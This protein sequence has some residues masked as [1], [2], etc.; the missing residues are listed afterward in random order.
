M[1]GADTA[2]HYN[3]ADLFELVAAEIGDRTAIVGGGTRLTY[4]ELDERTNRFAHHLIDSGA[5]VG[6]R[7]AIYSWNRVEWV[8][9]MMGAFKARMTPINV[10][11]RYVADELRYILENSDADVL[12]FERSFAPIV[13]KVRG[14]LP[15][16]AHFVILEDGTNPH[17]GDGVF[18]GGI[19]YEDAL[20]R[21]SADPIGVERSS[22]D[23]YILYT[24]GTT[25]LPKGVM[26]RHEDLFFAALGGGGYGQP[27]IVTP[28]EIVERI[29]PAETALRS[30]TL[31]P[32]MHGAAQWGMIITLFAGGSVTL[33]TSR[34]FDPHEAWRLAEAEGANSILV[35]GDAMARPLAEVLDEDPERYDLSSVVAIGS[36]GAVF[37]TAVKHQLQAHLPDLFITDTF[38]ASELGSA[39]SQHDP[40]AGPNFPHE[41]HMSVLDDDLK[42]TPP[43]VI[44][45][46]ARRGHMPIGYL[47]DEAKT[48][49]TFVTD[50]DGVRWAIPGD[51]CRFEED[52]TITLLG[53]GSGCINTG[54][55][56]VFPE[57]VEAAL[58]SHPGVFDVLVVGIPDER[59]TE[60]RRGRR[61]APGGSRRHPREPGVPR[62]L[63]DRRLQGPACAP[64]GRRHRAYGVGQGRLPLGEAAVRMTEQ[65]ES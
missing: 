20:A 45:R 18:D 15:N 32:V 39:G 46:L 13:E 34:G 4:R 58:K 52:G 50:D 31:A 63:P 10:N 38:G 40:E 59:F 8:E 37:S 65:D 12:V 57:E 9:A 3:I 64:T 60:P 42:P 54:G 2:R 7:V 47:G 24:G 27:D 36:G 56:K 1:K 5:G 25:G 44:G 11:Y 53:R 30:L 19:S 35:V 51:F 6:A 23:V 55:E 33:S 16:L 14:D 62:P 17:E 28:T 29:S 49:A 21:S 22:D 26:W 43:G 41:P 61:A 48:A